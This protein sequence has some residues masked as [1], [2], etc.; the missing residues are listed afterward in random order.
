MKA[1][2]LTQPWATLV[3]IG[4]KRIETRSWPTKYRGPLAIHAAKGFP[5]WAKANVLYDWD[6]FGALRPELSE[7]YQRNNVSI[8]PCAAGYEALR[9]LPLGSVIATCRLANC[10]PTEVI[11]NAANVFSVSLDPLSECERAFGDYSQ[12]RYAWILE[13]IKP[14]PEPIPAKGALGLWEW[15]EYPGECASDLGI[16][17]VPC[18]CALES[19]SICPKH[20]PVGARDSCI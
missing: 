19:S 10:L 15:T 3:A 17:G 8:V 2:T 1:L 14:F 18:I 9:S 4:A 13:D 20:G 12:G 5:K 6:F 11:D 7:H 16:P